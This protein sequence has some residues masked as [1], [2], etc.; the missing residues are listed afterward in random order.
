MEWVRKNVLK[1]SEEE[2]QELDKQMQ[3]TAE[4]QPPEEEMG[5]E[6]GEQY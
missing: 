5:M 3:A 4:E 2:I 1:Q 6:Q